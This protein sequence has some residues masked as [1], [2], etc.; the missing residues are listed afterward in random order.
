MAMNRKP[1]AEFIARAARSAAPL[2]AVATSLAA[3]LAQAASGDL[4]PSF[5][6]RGRLDPIAGATGTAWSIDALD[7]G[8]FFVGGGDVGYGWQCWY[9]WDCNVSASSYAA[10]VGADGIG[11]PEFVSESADHVQAFGIARQADGKIVAA[12]R[13]VDR[14]VHHR[15][16]SGLAVFRLDA[17]GSL[18]AGFGADGLFQLPGDTLGSNSEARA[19]R[20]D[21]DGRIVV[22]GFRMGAA[23]SPELV[24]LRLTPDGQPDST[25]GAD[26]IYVGPALAQGAGIGLARAAAGGY[27]IAA[28]TADGCAVVG[29]TGSGATDL[30][31]GS[32][33]IAA[34][35]STPGNT[36]TCAALEQQPDG[37][38]LVAGSAGDRGFVARLLAGG[39]RDAS[40][41]ADD[42]VADTVY[43]VN[44][45]A[46]S[47]G[48][49]VFVAGSGLKGATVMRLQATGALDAE[50][51][52]AGRAWID[53]DTEYAG[54][55][56]VVEIAAR[57]D[58][59]VL[60]VGNDGGSGQPFA[61]RLQGA[62]GGASA[63]VVGFAEGYV[64]AAEADGQALIH[65]RRS[66]GSAGAVHVDW[67]TVADSDAT[68][69]EDYS[70]ASGRIHW[71]DGESGEREIAVPIAEDAGAPE[72]YE[73]IHLA[74]GDP[75]GGAGAGAR[76]TTIYISPDGA[77]AG[78]ISVNWYT[79]FTGEAGS[80]E[81]YLSRDYYS[82]G[83]VS[84]TVTF[85]A[86]SAAAG[87]DFPADPVTVTWAAGDAEQKVVQLSL[88]DDSEREGRERFNFELS[89]PTGGAILGN[90][91]SGV[92]T[93]AES[94]MPVREPP[95]P[96]RGGGGGASGFLSLFLFGFLQ[97]A[98]GRRRT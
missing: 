91:T 46:A 15:L 88:P 65:L 26:G 27:R 64:E 3:P 57:S 94:D 8:S 98:R 92:I 77:P 69:G 32:A 34:V 14:M 18:D 95:P 19:V 60:A 9:D 1:I 89:N 25:F 93:I 83:E 61:V 52:D 11:D 59:G 56:S 40:F 49:G 23:G 51:G 10:R 5:A 38:L 31:F 76:N 24:V 73:G 62:N 67:R 66:G 70:S 43:A 37:S 81:I 97:L 39:A 84:V 75:A 17:D 71:A 47:P 80:A 6:D 78:Q 63:G 30:A 55:T 79:D 85:D 48:G 4:D 7:D 90:S 50:F 45:V 54:S 21:A 53:L 58:G 72:G 35:E 22:A 36:V 16:L 28:T 44:S 96:P 42:V 86:I 29:L 13:Y 41:A 74:L 82:E 33:G 87:D 12:G 68:E 2:A 20:V